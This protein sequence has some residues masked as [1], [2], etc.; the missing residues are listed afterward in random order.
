MSKDIDFVVDNNG[1]NPKL[2]VV[3]DVRI[4]NLGDKNKKT[5]KVWFRFFSFANS[6]L[7]MMDQTI[8]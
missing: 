6:T 5:W 3:D 2:K 1:K 7:V 8:I 4:S